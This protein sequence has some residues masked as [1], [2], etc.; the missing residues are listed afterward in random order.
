[1][2]KRR[3]KTIQPLNVGE[4]GDD[5]LNADQ[6]R[7]KFSTI[8][9]K[10]NRR[11][12]QLCRQAFDALVYVLN[13]VTGDDTLSVM[14]VT[15][16]ADA[17]RI[18]VTLL[19]DVPADEFDRDAIMDHL[20]ACKGQLRFEIASAINRRKTPDLSFVVFRQSE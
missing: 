7:R 6:Y 16:G 14:S 1:M 9:P 3:K 19:A 17:S 4:F 12:K 15:P 8:P 13:E 20:Q 18:C 10:D 2:S 11:A 5:G